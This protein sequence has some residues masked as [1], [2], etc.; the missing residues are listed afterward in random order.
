[1]QGPGMLPAPPLSSTFKNVT[2]ERM[3]KA[4][5]A[6]RKYLERNNGVDKHNLADDVYNFM[7]KQPGDIGYATT[8]LPRLQPIMPGG[9]FSGGSGTGA[10]I[11]Q[12]IGGAV[13]IGPQTP[14]QQMRQPGGY[15]YEDMRFAGIPK[16]QP[17]FGLLLGQKP[18]PEMFYDR[19]TGKQVTQEQ[20]DSFGGMQTLLTPSQR[21][22]V[23]ERDRAGL[24]DMQAAQEKLAQKN[25]S[26]RGDS[27]GLP[28]VALPDYLAGIRAENKTRQDKI[29]SGE[30]VRD[31]NQRDRGP[32][33]YITK[34]E[35]DALR[36]T[37]EEPVFGGQ[38][39]GGI[40]GLQQF[41]Q[42]MQMIIQ[43]VQQSQGMGMGGM[44]M[45][46]GGMGGMRRNNFAQPQ[47]FGSFNQYQSR[48]QYRPQFQQNF[49]N[50]Y[51]PY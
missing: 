26:G 29:N 37:N 4:E 36:P 33:R 21:S 12:L 15:S 18:P 3:Q 7:S 10:K 22:S 34:A 48:Q 6:R 2:P 50:P 20:V 47:G 49:N 24:H 42:I 38:T 32:P 31:P 44:G 19:L 43:M 11:P 23:L 30:L 13:G 1:M 35:A 46:M 8:G 28:A 16:V 14:P 41:M 17:A 27:G 39:G 51:G 9:Q 45:G 40:G 25:M 5:E